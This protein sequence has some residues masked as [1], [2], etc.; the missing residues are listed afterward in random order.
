MAR[1]YWNWSQQ[2]LA[3]RAGV[4]LNTVSKFEKEEG[5]TAT[6]TI[7]KLAT[8]VSLSG[9]EVLDGGGVRPTASAVTVLEG[10]EGFATFMD[11]VYETMRAEGGTYRV[12]NVSEANW[13]KWLGE[14]DARKRRERTTALKNVSARILVH[15]GDRLLTATDYAEYRSIPDGVFFEGVSGYIYGSK[16]AIIHFEPDD[17]RVMILRDAAFADAQ[18]CWFDAVWDTAKAS[19]DD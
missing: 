9:L 12:S 7:E 8:T 11:D 6:D 4:S 19:G 5:Q 14:D 13:L 10:A 16:Y 15:E 17:V 2:D 1:A 18:R 3:D